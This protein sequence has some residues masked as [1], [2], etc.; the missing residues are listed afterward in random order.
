MADVGAGKATYDLKREIARIEEELTQLSMPVSE[1]QE[2]ITPTNL[3]RANE[4]LSKINKKQRE[5]LSMYLRY[6]TSL[7]KLFSSMFEIQMDLKEILKE[8][9][10]L[11]P[12]KEEKIPR[13]KKK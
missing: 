11:I 8:Q 9:S 1:I 4:H 5:L 3:L 13:Q 12:N 6:S 2:M 7:E 10:S